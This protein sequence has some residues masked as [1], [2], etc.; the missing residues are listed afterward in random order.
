MTLVLV[1]ACLAVASLELF[2]AFGRNRRDVSTVSDLQSRTEALGAT[3]T[4]LAAELTALRAELATRPDTASVTRLS[5]KLDAA[6]EDLTS[7][8]D[9]SRRTHEEFTSRHHTTTDDLRRTQ[10]ALAARL[11]ATAY[12]LRHVEDTLTTQIS[13][14]PTEEL[15]ER[16]GELDA[17][18]AALAARLH[19]LEAGADTRVDPGGLVE[20]IGDLVSADTE[21][22]RRLHVLE[23]AMGV[24]GGGVTV[25][26]LFARAE[27]L[28]EQ[29]RGGDGQV[30][31][32]VETS[33]ALVARMDGL[34]ARQEDL[35]ERLE[36]LRDAR[37]EAGE[38]LA[39]L[40]RARAELADRLETLLPEITSRQDGQN[41]VINALSQRLGELADAE[42]HRGELIALRGQTDQALERL[43][44][45]D[46]ERDRDLERYRD[47]AQALDAVEDLLAGQ[48]AEAEPTTVR[49]GLSGDA[50]DSHELLTKTYDDFVDTMDLRVRMQVPSGSTPWQTQYYLAGKNPARLRRDFSTL[51]SALHSGAPD[52]RAD[53]LHKLATAMTQTDQSYAQIG[54]LALIRLGDTLLCGI[55]TVAENRR[56]DVDRF[57][58]DPSATAARLRLLPDTRFRDLST[59][60]RTA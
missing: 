48:R 5:R 4:E 52:P 39:E 33:G 58:A 15:A 57:L 27:K 37:D 55:L 56:F 51:L 54:P 50:P 16:I 20:R 13:A 8:L 46:A 49:G 47:L 38:R 21:L 23:A 28:E 2:L 60:P 32:L 45:L 44:E 1:V 40:Q 41:G 9:A 18:D 42:G 19:L 12:D 25:G 24:T 14:L 31:E 30:R 7:R 35:A 17:A 6:A 11:D 22:A 34:W 43:D 10:D 26:E 29:V 59:W 36:E 3:L 53:S